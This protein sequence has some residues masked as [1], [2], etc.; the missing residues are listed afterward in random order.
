MEWMLRTGDFRGRYASR[1]EMLLGLAMAAVNAGWTFSEYVESILTSAA[2]EKLRGRTAQAAEKYLKRCWAKA[3]QR[4]VTTPPVRNRTD[5]QREIISI[6]EAAFKEVMTWSG[7][8]GATDAKVLIGHLDLAFEVG[9]PTY[10]VSV[11]TLANRTV[12]PATTVARSHRRLIKRGWLSLICG[13]GDG[14]ELGGQRSRWPW[15]TSCARWWMILRSSPARTRQTF[16]RL[17]T[18]PIL[19]HFDGTAW[20]ADIEARFAKKSQAGPMT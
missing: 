12:I 7:A 2:G 6:F 16:S 17:L 3:V 11:R 5:A 19:V 18:R 8:A 1:S 10:H 4:A 13:A 20:R 15:R 14:G 9:S